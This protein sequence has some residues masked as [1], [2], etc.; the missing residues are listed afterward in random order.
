MGYDEIEDKP[1]GPLLSAPTKKPDDDLV[2]DYDSGRDDLILTLDGEFSTVEPKMCRGDDQVRC[3]NSAEY[4]C[5]VQICDGNI[6]CSNGADEE[7]CTSSEV[8][9]AAPTTTTPAQTTTPYCNYFI[10]L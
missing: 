3:G 1:K 5:D 10:F 9:T 7:N 6:D 8:T 4:I 2:E